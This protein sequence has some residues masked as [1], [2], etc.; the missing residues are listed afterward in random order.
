MKISRIAQLGAVAAIA[1]LTLTAC[2]SN[3]GGTTAPTETDAPTLS[4]SLSGSGAT[5]QQVAIQAWTAEFQKAN[6]DVTVNYDPQGSG[7]GRESFQEGAVQ[8]AGSDRA[9]KVEEIEAGLGACAEGADPVELPTYI[10]PIAIIFNLDGVDSLNIDPATLGGIFAGTITKWNDPAIAATNSGVSLPDAAITP[11]HRS[12]K[13]GTTGNFTDY[14]AATSGGSWTFGSVEEWPIQGGEAAQGTSGVV[15]AV[16]GGA[17]TIGYADSSQAGGI[18]SVKVQ[19]GDDWV[20]HSAEGAAKTVDVSPIEDG[21]ASTDLAITIDRTTTEAGA[22]PVI[23][24]SYLIGCT[25]YEDANI[26]ALVKGFFGTAV[27][28]AGQETAAKNAGSA[29]ISDAL[30]EKAQAAVDAIK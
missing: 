26:G 28:E 9:F 16:K 19:V 6:P 7:A 4:G 1:A 14:L 8:F 18:A 27:S 5:S 3:E 11:V 2:A 12:D 22:Y 13:S 10:S 20:E 24:I 17:G 23:L 25:E 15:N 29:P 30:R 21:R